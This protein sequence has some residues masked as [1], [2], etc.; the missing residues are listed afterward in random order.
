MRAP[1]RNMCSLH[2]GTARKQHGHA[3]REHRT[4]HRTFVYARWSTAQNRICQSSARFRMME[5]TAR[6]HVY[7]VEEKRAE[8]PFIPCFLRGR[9]TQDTIRV[10]STFSPRSGAAR[11][12]TP[13]DTTLHVSTR[14][15]TA[16]YRWSGHVCFMKNRKIQSSM[17]A[18]CICTG[19]ANSMCLLLRA[20]HSSM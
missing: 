1:H 11:M 5:D 7:C 13:P 3:R 10:C 16:P 6:S 20:D 18:G 17:E 15:R 9:K 14:L 2:E 19:P 8:A 12:M 4:G